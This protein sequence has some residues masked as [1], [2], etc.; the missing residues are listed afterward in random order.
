MEHD[1][2]PHSSR[3]KAKNTGLLPLWEKAGDFFEK[4][5]KQA[6]NYFVK[7]LTNYRRKSSHLCLKWREFV[8][9]RQKG[10]QKAQKIVLIFPDSFDIMQSRAERRAP[11]D[12]TTH[13]WR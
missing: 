4:E 2:I 8:T 5:K 7:N 1:C 9:L 11:Y 12:A 3:V 6:K 13:F 10:G